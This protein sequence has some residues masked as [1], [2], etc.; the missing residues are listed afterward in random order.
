MTDQQSNNA[1]K[2]CKNQ[3]KNKFF[4]NII[5]KEERGHERSKKYDEIPDLL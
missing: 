5:G 3:N 2:T 4:I 1:N